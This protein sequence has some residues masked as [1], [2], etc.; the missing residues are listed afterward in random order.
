MAL[1]RRGMHFG[2]YGAV[3]DG[4]AVFDR[5][6]QAV[7]VAEDAGFDALS[8][9]DHVFQNDMAVAGG[10]SA[11]MFEAY[12]LLG[13]LAGHTRTAKLFAL[14]T[15]VTFRNPAYLA[16]VVTTLDVISGGRAILGLGAGWDVSEHD[17]YGY[18]FP[19][20]SE[21]MDRLDETATICRAMFRTPL[22]SFTGNHY[23]IQG[24]Y[25]APRPVGGNIPILI[26]G[27]G[28]RRTLALVARHADACNILGDAA[29]VRHKLDVLESHCRDIGRDPGEITK[30]V[31]VFGI[32]DAPDL[33]GEFR[34][35]ADAGAEGAV[36]MTSEDR[37]R[38]EALGAALLE[39]WP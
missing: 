13:A 38:I 8:M 25:N 9:P 21:R 18:P 6:C 29:Q 12:T 26:G 5:L 36:V 16:K 1:F 2:S 33:V 24:A 35:I 30:T 32:D 14:V 37:S 19:S 3:D 34:R 4:S 22:P 27:G 28:E 7:R 10:P 39:V 23:R 15:P 20:V 17:A 31:F 11:P